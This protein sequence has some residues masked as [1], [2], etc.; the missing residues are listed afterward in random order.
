MK[1]TLLF[2]LLALMCNGIYS[3]SSKEVKVADFIEKNSFTVTNST[4][5]CKVKFNSEVRA[6]T[7]DGYR[8]MLN[9]VYTKITYS[10]GLYFVVFECV[11]GNNCI[12][13]PNGILRLEFAIPFGNR[14]KCNDFIRIIDSL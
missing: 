11:S 13:D 1:K 3:Q 10:E 12:V 8:I 6:L 14:T 9:R 4:G 7:I 5:K 2:V